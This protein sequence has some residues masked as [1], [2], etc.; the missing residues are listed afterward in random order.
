MFRDLF[1]EANRANVSFYP[2]DPRGLSVFDT[3]IGPDPPLGRS[4][5][6]RSWSRQE[7]LNTLAVNTDGLALIDSND[8]RNRSGV[9]RT[10]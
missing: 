3:P 4:R 2:I 9:S 10:T 5:I 6:T 8:L 1:G 7:S